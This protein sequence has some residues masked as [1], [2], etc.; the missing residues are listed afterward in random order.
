MLPS[1]TTRPAG[2]QRRE[3]LRGE[4]EVPERVAADEQLEPVGG[5][6]DARR[7]AIT[8]PGVVHESVDRAERGELAGGARASIPARSGRGARTRP[9][10]AGTRLRIDPIAASALSR[11]R[12]AM[13]TRPPARGQL[14]AREV[15][16]AGV[17]AGDHE[18]L[19]GLRGQVPGI[20]DRCHRGGHEAGCASVEIE[21]VAKRSW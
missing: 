21:P 9:R 10:R 20:P 7:G 11:L 6:A 2:R 15:A 17:A 12:A 4:R 1:P 16:D 3:E 19:A 8:R 13:I 5:D 14:L 18:R